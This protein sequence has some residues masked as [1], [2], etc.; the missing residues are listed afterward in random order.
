MRSIQLS[1]NAFTFLES[2]KHLAYNFLQSFMG[3]F[4]KI[5]TLHRIFSNFDSSTVRILA[6]PPLRY[7]YFETVRNVVGT[8]AKWKR[9]I[10][11]KSHYF[12]VLLKFTLYFLGKEAQYN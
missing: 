3:Y 4:A 6:L 5:N 10:V 11:I 2:V 8:E 7:R 12:W 1:Y 9:G